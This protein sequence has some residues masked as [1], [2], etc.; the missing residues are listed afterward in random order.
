M[1]MAVATVACALNRSTPRQSRSR[2]PYSPGTRSRPLSVESLS[3]AR[4]LQLGVVGGVAAA[5]V[6]PARTG[7]TS[8]AGTAKSCRSHHSRSRGLCA[9]GVSL[10]R[11]D[12]H[13][14]GVRQSGTSSCPPQPPRRPPDR[15]TP[16]RA[17]SPG[18]CG[19]V[20]PGRSRHSCSRRLYGA[21]VASRASA[22]RPLQPIAGRDP[23]V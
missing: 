12:D 14:N 10:F 17:G 9:A 15:V 18:T 6:T 3:L 4:T 19:A 21:G 11:F 20:R 8:C 1:R 5:R 23:C 7:A 16:A 13:T 22:L 2:G